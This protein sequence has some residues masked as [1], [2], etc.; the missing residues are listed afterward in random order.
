MKK[1]IRARLIN[2]GIDSYIAD[3]VI[4]IISKKEE[5]NNRIAENIRQTVAI[6]Q[7]QATLGK[8][9]N[10][11]LHEG[12]RPLNFFK[13]E[14][15]NLSFWAGKIKK[16]FSQEYLDEIIPIT[17]GL[18]F[19]AKI[20][21]DLFSRLDPLAAGKRGP[22]STFN[23]LSTLNNA[24]KVFEHEFND[25]NI[26]FNITCPS[27][28]NF[29]G[30]SQDIYIIMTNLVDNSVFWMIEKSSKVKH[31]EITVIT[32]DSQL[33]Y[34]DYRDTGPGI[35]EELIKREVIFEPEFS[36]KT[37]GTGLGLAIAGESATRNGL[38][39]K[40]FAAEQGAYFRLQVQ[41]EV[42]L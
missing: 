2:Q 15:P 16:N 31:I 6:Y 41:Q 14:I 4:D 9:I 7:G 38:E 23:V 39:L 12:R 36:T 17:E 29:R 24:L 26:T 19:N 35:A 18:G 30:W 33:D 40:V 20:F 3:E 25:K 8:I 21:A 34:I 37:S 32:N 22:K 10:V 27:D 42:Q 28:I 11:I 1:G 5:E 13:N